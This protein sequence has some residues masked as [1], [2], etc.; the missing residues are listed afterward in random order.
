M[1]IGNFVKRV[2]DIMRQDAGV[3]GDAQRIEQ[4][5]WML[6]LKIYDDAE[7]EWDLLEDN[8]E[9]IIPEE[10]RWRNWADTRVTNLSM[11]K[12]DDLISFVNNELFPKL[13]TLQLPPNCPKNN[14]GGAG[15]FTH[16]HVRGREPCA[17]AL[18][19]RS[20]FLVYSSPA[21]NCS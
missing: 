4:L 2:S 14:H 3:N 20:L 12:G 9:S 1:S 21:K 5:T 15:F 10:C 19:L 7:S 13:R 6:F 11:R 16:Y 18:R 17:G 8:F